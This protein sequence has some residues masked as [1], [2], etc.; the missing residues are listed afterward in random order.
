M[1]LREGVAGA[2]YAS[3]HFSRGARASVRW[4]PAPPHSLR[5]GPAFSLPLNRIRHLDATPRFSYASLASRCPPHQMRAV[6]CRRRGRLS[7]PSRQWA[8]VGAPYAG[9]ASAGLGPWGDS[10]DLSVPSEE[11]WSQGCR[12]DWRGCWTIDRAEHAVLRSLAR[13]STFRFIV[14]V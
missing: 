10:S 13:G 8:A 7:F 1:E 9:G 2:L 3:R 6:R 14:P 12:R 11:Q 5:Q 4:E